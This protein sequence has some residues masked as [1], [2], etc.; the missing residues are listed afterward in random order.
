MVVNLR[1]GVGETASNHIY[2]PLLSTGLAVDW[3]RNIA[4]TV[5]AVLISYNNP[6]RTTSIRKMY[7]ASFEVCVRSATCHINRAT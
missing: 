2:I 5:R 6:V 7:A 4:E 1:R 3:I